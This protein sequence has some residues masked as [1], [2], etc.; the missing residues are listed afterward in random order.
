MR[1]CEGYRLRPVRT[2]RV[3]IGGHQDGLVPRCRR[4]SQVDVVPTP[5]SP[6]Y[7]G[8]GHRL[9]DSPVGVGGHGDALRRSTSSRDGDGGRADGE[10]GVASGLGDGASDGGGRTAIRGDRQLRGQ[11]TNRSV[12]CDVREGNGERVL[13][14][15]TRVASDSRSVV[16]IDR[17]RRVRRRKHQADAIRTRQSEGQLGR[18]G[19][20]SD[21][22]G[23]ARLFNGCGCRGKTHKIG[24]TRLDDVEGLVLHIGSREGCIGLSL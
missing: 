14:G 18:V 19:S 15:R 24:L 5:V 2:A 1:G 21:C 6:R 3:G 11:R 13:L 20:T 23:S 17:V 9:G 7:C 16:R 4:V 8:N 22:E 10:V 12:L